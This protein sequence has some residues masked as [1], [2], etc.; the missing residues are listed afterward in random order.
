MNMPWADDAVK[1]FGVFGYGFV[2]VVMIL[3]A[4]LM[5]LALLGTAYKVVGAYLRGW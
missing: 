4:P 5:P 1:R 3:V 2:A